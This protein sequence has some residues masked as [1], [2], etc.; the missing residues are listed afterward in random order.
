MG[1]ATEKR[2]VGRWSDRLNRRIDRSLVRGQFHVIGLLAIAAIVVAVTSAIAMLALH[3]IPEPTGREDGPGAALWQALV[4]TIDPGQI[5]TDHGAAKFIGFATTIVGLLLISTLISIVNNQVERRVDRVRRGRDPV[6]LRRPRR[7]DTEAVPY[8]IVLGWTDLTLRLLEELADSHLPHR[9]PDVLVMAPMSYDDM[10]ERIEEYRLN[11]TIDASTSATTVLQRLPADREWPQVRTGTPTDTRDLHQI[12]AITRADSVIILAPEPPDGV[13]PLVSFPD[14]MSPSTAEVIKTL[15][16][17]SACLPD[18]NQV[19]NPGDPAARAV[20]RPTVVVELPEGVQSDS[21]LADRIRARICDVEM[22]L[23]TVDVTTVQSN[24]AANVSRTTGL[25]AVYRDLLDFK[26]AEFHIVDP[27]PELRTFGHAVSATR[28]G[29]VVGTIDGAGR[30]DL[31]PE[32]DTDLSGRQLITLQDDASDPV[33]DLDRPPL[34]GPRGAGAGAATEPEQV[35]LIG[36]NHRAEQLIRSLDHLLPA[37]SEVRVVTASPDVPSIDL[38]N[39]GRVSVSQLPDGIQNWLDGEPSELGCDHAVVLSD[40]RVPPAVSDANVLLT[41]LALRP[42]HSNC[43][44]PDTVVAELR[45]RP[46]RYLASQ[47]FSDDLI[48]GDSLISM[49]LAQSAAAPALS[50]VIEELISPTSSHPL[51]IRLIPLSSYAT[52][53]A[54]SFRAL[55][56]TVRA[57][58]GSIVLGYRT[59]ALTPSADQG[60]LHLNPDGNTPLPSSADG[61]VQLVVLTRCDDRVDQDPERLPVTTNRGT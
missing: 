60:A 43:D 46:N 1:E 28:S 14:E 32:W 48:V 58:D 41:L 5:T 45:Q 47:R 2:A 38:P 50:G 7:S 8:Y 18:R 36:W 33:V 27:H 20:E 49:V 53:P 37:G 23:V 13:P 56:A 39:V 59:P 44:K 9:P 19:R 52:V 17:V 11:T 51:E 24:L 54:G 55:Q 25:A 26:G 22:E 21:R 4:R 12:A 15:M 57:A 10:V 31:W 3:A 6:R 30:A 29:I 35:L 61:D 42:P 16:A 40:D 34:S